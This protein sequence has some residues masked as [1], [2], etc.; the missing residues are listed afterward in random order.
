MGR[1]VKAVESGQAD[2]SAGAANADGR[3][4][5]L[6]EATSLLVSARAMAN[7]ELAAAKEHSLLLARKMAERIVGRAVE[8]DP[9][10][11]GEIAAQ[12]LAAMRSRPG[13]LV[14][15][16]HPEDLEAVERTRK[17]WLRALGAA[18]DV[19]IIADPSVGRCGCVVDTKA[20]RLDARL[21]SQLDALESALR[22]TNAKGTPRV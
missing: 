10:V 15:R 4:A 5:V 8:I 1:I 21:Q 11:M 12:A 18:A 6:A 16:V 17:D 9:A 19:R 14:L 20:G 22:G 7:A 13:A 3:E 2:V